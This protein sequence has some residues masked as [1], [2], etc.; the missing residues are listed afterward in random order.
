MDARDQ[1][2]IARVMELGAAGESLR[3]RGKYVDS[4]HKFEE[5]KAEGD[6]IR[7]ADANKAR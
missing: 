6:K 7:D 3:A 2:L 5:A 1:A 4:L